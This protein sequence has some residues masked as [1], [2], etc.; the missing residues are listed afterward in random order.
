M[1]IKM[2]DINAIV[3]GCNDKILQS[4]ATINDG[5]D[6]QSFSFNTSEL[7]AYSGKNCEENCPIWKI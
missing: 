4:L 1:A 2:E 7:I 5:V 3:K 6:Y